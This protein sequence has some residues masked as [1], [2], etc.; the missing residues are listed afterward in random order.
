[1]Y[2]LM[3]KSKELLSFNLTDSG[4]IINLTIISTA[5]LPEN[6]KNPNELALYEWLKSRNLD[7]TRSNARL[8]LK[9]MKLS[10]MGIT[11][12]IYNR[13]LN[14]T[15]C[16]WIRHNEQERFEDFSLYQ[17]HHNKFVMETSLSGAIHQLTRVINTELTNI[18]SFNKAW[19]KTD[20]NWYLCKKGDA[21]SF[22][23]ELF[24]CKLGK[25][26]GMSMAEYKFNSE[27]AVIETKNFTSETQML[28]HYATL[29]S[30]FGNYSE[31][32]EKLIAAGMA[33]IS[34]ECYIE[35]TNMLLLDGLISNFDRHEYN[36]GVLKSTDTGK[37]LRFA[38]NFD[39]NLALG[40]GGHKTTTYMLKEYLAEFGILPHQQNLLNHLSMDLVQCIDTEV[41]QEL[42]LQDTNYVIAHFEE[43]FEILK[44]RHPN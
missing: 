42:K 23:A 26:L 38:P 36:F 14:L 4:N 8:L 31:V 11:P 21:K 24:A 25:I 43:V 20:N 7:T 41:K 34:N 13:A 15:D 3:C 12:T 35:Y 44:K 9:L 40:A 17:K 18:G 28:E 29:K 32:E 27:L 5:L 6:L 37:I 10:G 30:K 2:T 22:Y 1:M 16:Y 39:N 19:I 33:S